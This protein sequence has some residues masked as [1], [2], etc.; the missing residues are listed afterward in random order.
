MDLVAHFQ[1][2]RNAVS[3]Q[4]GQ[5][6]FSEGE[7]G[8]SMFVL[9]EGTASVCVGG[10]VLEIARP[11]ALLGEMALVDS[12]ARSASVIAGAGCRVLAVDRRQFDMLVRESPEFAR[13]VMTVMADRLRRMN[14][15]LKEALTEL[16]VRGNRPRP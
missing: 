16:S 15:R 2:A 13:H 3:L 10:E 8:S 14:E 12:A 5:V 4:A 6:L 11:G 9:I 1:Q 7:P